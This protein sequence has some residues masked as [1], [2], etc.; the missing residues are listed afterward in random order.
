M[1]DPARVVVVDDPITQPVRLLLYSEDG[2]IA[3]ANLDAAA[4]ARLLEGLAT[5][6]RRRTQTQQAKDDLP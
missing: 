3:S 2:A 4:I 5:A 6:L 1:T